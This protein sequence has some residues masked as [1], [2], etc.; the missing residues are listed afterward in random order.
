MIISNKTSSMNYS[1]RKEYFTEIVLK[2]WK[3]SINFN[4]I[5]TPKEVL[6]I[7]IKL[8]PLYRL[9]QLAKVKAKSKDKLN[10]VRKKA[11]S[12]KMTI[13]SKPPKDC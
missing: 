3:D 10:I 2:D 8:N 6:F 5:M 1:K 11:Q 12:I 13:P 9:T 4:P 7:A